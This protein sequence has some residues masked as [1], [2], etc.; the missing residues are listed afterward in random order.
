[1]EVMRSHK[2][3]VIS[4]LHLMYIIIII[5][6][7]IIIIILSSADERKSSRLALLCLAPGIATYL[8]APPSPLGPLSYGL[9]K[10][11]CITP[12]LHK[13]YTKHYLI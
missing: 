5:T 7:I 8:S 1:M 11:L 4:R 13:Y 3:S 12:H 6:I 10:Y 2:A 9:Y